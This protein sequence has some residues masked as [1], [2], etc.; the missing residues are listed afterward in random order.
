VKTH[1]H[2][3]YTVISAV[4]IVIMTNVS[5][6]C[7]QVVQLSS[8]DYPALPLMWGQTPQQIVEIEQIDLR[9]TVVIGD[10]SLSGLFDASFMGSNYTAE[11]IFSWSTTYKVWRLF[12][13]RLDVPRVD[14]KTDFRILRV[15][16]EEL[17]YRN[18]ARGSDK[19]KG[20]FY[21]LRS[22][23]N[24]VQFLNSPAK[25]NLTTIFVIKLGNVEVFEIRKSPPMPEHRERFGLLVENEDFQIIIDSIFVLQDRYWKKSW[26]GKWKFSIKNNTTEHYFNG[27]TV[28]IELAIW[29]KYFR[30]A[31]ADVKYL[32]VELA[33]SESAS[34]EIDVPINDHHTYQRL[35]VG[36]TWINIWKID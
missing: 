30:A 12:Q 32:K 35:K 20:P 31:F 25:P 15:H 7:E 9:D 29:D 13:V 34:Y 22:Q 3:L 18:G 33:P 11:A 36:T 19:S 16:Y 27:N 14:E 28:Q 6:R 21:Q 5:L 17:G 4:L 10:N 8:N 26:S 23:Y 1:S 24:L 2:V